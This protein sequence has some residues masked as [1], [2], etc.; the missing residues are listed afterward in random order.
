M[1]IN[2]DQLRKCRTV[3]GQISVYDAVSQVF[4]CS[5]S[6]AR[7]RVMTEFG[8]ENF[9][10]IQFSGSIPTPVASIHIIIAVLLRLQGSCDGRKGA[11]V[12]LAAAPV[13]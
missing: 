8:M 2:A 6:N 13:V 11:T 1:K 7:R 3:N 9:A 12:Q 5:R 4:K 10:Y